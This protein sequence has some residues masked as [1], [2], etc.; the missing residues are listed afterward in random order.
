M[1]GRI[2]LLGLVLGVAGIAGASD[3]RAFPVLEPAHLLDRTMPDAF[4]PVG[5]KRHGIHRGFGGGHKGFHGRRFHKG[6]HGHRFH[7]GFHGH[8][9]FAGKRLPH[10]GVFFRQ[11]FV[12]PGFFLGLRFRH[13][14]LFVRQRFAGP[15]LFFRHPFGHRDRIVRQRF[16]GPGFL[17]DHRFGHRGPGFFPGDRFRDRPSLFG[18]HFHDRWRR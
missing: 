4:M 15:G 12:D 1:T 6:F 13:G 2:L 5:S 8:R 7:K 10:G 18:R 9:L 16:A 3:A 17:F 11:R 14:D